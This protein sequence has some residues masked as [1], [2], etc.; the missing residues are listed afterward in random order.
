MSK[1]TGSICAYDTTSEFRIFNTRLSY[2]KGACFLHMLRSVI[3]NDSEYFRIHK[4]YQQEKKGS[5]GTIADMKTVAISIFGTSVN[6][7]S[8]DTFFNQWVYQQGYPIYNVSWTK[9]EVMCWYNSTSLP[10]HPHQ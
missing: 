10:P 5:T 2:D 6:G 3:N 4:S 8:F 9:G 1:D 7:I